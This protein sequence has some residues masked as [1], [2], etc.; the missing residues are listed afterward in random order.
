MMLPLQ[1]IICY[2]LPLLLWYVRE[3]KLVVSSVG[4]LSVIVCHSLRHRKL[5]NMQTQCCKYIHIASGYV[6]QSPEHIESCGAKHRQVISLQHLIC[7][8]P[9]WGCGHTC[10]VHTLQLLYI[11][12][13]PIIIQI[14]DCIWKNV[15][16]S[17]IQFFKLHYS[18]NLSRIADRCESSKDCKITISLSFL[19]VSYL[20]TI[21]CGFYRS[22]NEQ[23][24][25][26][27]LCIYSYT[28][29][30]CSS[31]AMLFITI[32]NYCRVVAI[33]L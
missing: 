32:T 1:L 31:L 5:I 23:N 24:W 25:M 28:V 2:Q 10:I 13:M 33:R 18:Q 30:F 17:H 22:P 16:N 9:M 11:L 3:G 21:P 29:V 7:T 8:L 19:K 14:C 26:H 20:Y 15:H 12:L 27:E 6:T 4:C